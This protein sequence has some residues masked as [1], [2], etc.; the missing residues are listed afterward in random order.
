MA[1]HRMKKLHFYSLFIDGV[2]ST[3]RNEQL[4]FHRVNAPTSEELN[5][6]VATISERVAR[7]QERQ[8]RPARVAR[9]GSLGQGRPARDGRSM[10][11]K[12]EVRRTWL[13]V[14]D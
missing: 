11:H 6:L 7:Y 14:V 4:R 1:Q 3:M 2:F 8:G 10:L 5:A 9:P 13:R 12:E